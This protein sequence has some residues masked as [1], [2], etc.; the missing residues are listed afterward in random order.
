[1][2]HTCAGT[3]ADGLRANGANGSIGSVRLFPKWTSP[4][5]WLAACD[6]GLR[7][8][9]L[10][11]APPVSRRQL[12]CLRDGHATIPEKPRFMSKLTGMVK[13]PT[14]SVQSSTCALP[15]VS[16]II[17]GA[18]QRLGR[19]AVER[20]EP[21]AL[22]SVGRDGPCRI[23]RTDRDESQPTEIEQ[24]LAKSVTSFGLLRQSKL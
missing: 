1:M 4:R 12:S 17:H 3:D 23:P 16:L 15:S 22:V 18:Q 8:Y 19:A 14:T 2:A 13:P 9:A 24:L 10:P 11:P 20:V 6:C 5:V 7:Q 21:L